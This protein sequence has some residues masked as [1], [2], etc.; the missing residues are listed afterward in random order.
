M[1]QITELIVTD[2]QIKGGT[3]IKVAAYETPN[4]A[5][6]NGMFI[7]G[8]VLRWLMETRSNNMTRAI[9]P[10]DIRALWKLWNAHK[11]DLD[12]AQKNSDA[13]V[14]VIEM[15]RTI[16]LP[17][18]TEMRR[19]KNLKIQ[20]IAMEIHDYAFA[21]MSR[22]TAS[23][24][25]IVDMTDYAEIVEAQ[26]VVEQV[27]VLFVGTGDKKADGQWDTG[28]DLPAI[29][30]LGKEIPDGDLDALSF[31]EPSKTDVQAGLPDA[32][33]IDDKPVKP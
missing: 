8:K 23:G 7:I 24:T 6:F 30:E 20:R 11:L 25:N 12:L 10:A 18:P 4:K 15:Y 13:P 3:K 17:H 28:I 16:L 33:D 21:C 27:M 29:T 1:D 14:S 19:Y 9:Q 2:V 32:P 22:D 26:K 5:L 31:G